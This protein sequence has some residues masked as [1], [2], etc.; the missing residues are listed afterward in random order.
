M[1]CSSSA[2]AGTANSVSGKPIVTLTGISGYLGSLTCLEFIKDGGYR[3][4]GTV[5]DKD[6]QE[7]IAPLRT[8]FGAHFDKLELVN[9][10]LTDEQS[11]I[12][13]IKGSTYVVHLASPFFFSKDENALIKPAVDGTNAVMKA[14]E[15]AGVRRC[16]VTSSCASIFNVAST[17]KPAN[18]IFTEAN[19]SNPDRPE[20]IDGYSKSKTLAEKAAWDF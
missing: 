16:V 3:V 8:A 20:G 1:G 14:C 13:A 11:L 5:R 12:N 9:A 17:D 19:W 2:S 10:D 6:N 15:L 18:G 7:K 4:R